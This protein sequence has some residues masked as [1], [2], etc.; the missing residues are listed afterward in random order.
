MFFIEV[1]FLLVHSNHSTDTAKRPSRN[2][3]RK[4]N[5]SKRPS[6]AKRNNNIDHISDEGIESYGSRRMNDTSSERHTSPERRSSR[7]ASAERPLNSDEESVIPRFSP[8]AC[9]DLDLG[10]ELRKRI[11]SRELC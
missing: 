5:A 1:L 10:T 8:K 4:K 2:K 3:E 11:I 6:S 9:N 7:D